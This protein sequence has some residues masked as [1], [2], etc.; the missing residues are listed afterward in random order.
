MPPPHRLHRAIGGSLFGHWMALLWLFASVS[1]SQA[2][3]WR[4]SLYPANWK[5]PV[6]SLFASDKMIQDFSYA[7]YRRGEVGI[8]T[9]D[10]NVLNAVT[11]YGADPTGKTDSTDGDPDGP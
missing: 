7:G 8:P 9:P 11:K 10:G 5:P 4:S 1:L 6:E 3:T 2:Q